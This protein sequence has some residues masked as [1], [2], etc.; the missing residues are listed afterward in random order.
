MP[1][2]HFRNSFIQLGSLRLYKVGIAVVLGRRR[3]SAPSDAVAAGFSLDFEAIRPDS[4][5][6]G[7]LGRGAA[8]EVMRGRR[9]ARRERRRDADRALDVLFSHMSN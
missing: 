8:W 3:A 6:R 5:S 2:V 4:R 7:A 9:D 1:G